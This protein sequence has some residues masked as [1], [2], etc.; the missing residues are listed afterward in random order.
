MNN[1]SHEE[2]LKVTSLWK[3]YLFTNPEQAMAHIFSWMN[4]I[5]ELSKIS[6]P[7]AQGAK[8]KRGKNWNFWELPKVYNFVE[9]LMI[10]KVQ[11]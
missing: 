7:L 4:S 8:K 6:W 5:K 10:F 11:N 1:L 2:D 3:K 9:F